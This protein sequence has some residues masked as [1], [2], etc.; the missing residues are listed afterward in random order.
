MYVPASDA[1]AR[2]QSSHPV[3]PRHRPVADDDVGAAAARVRRAL[4]RH[5]PRRDNGD[6][7]VRSRCRARPVRGRRRP[8]RG[9]RA[10]PHPARLATHRRVDQR[11]I[12]ALGCWQSCG[13]MPV[14]RAVPT[15]ARA[16]RLRP[17]VIA[18][19][20][21]FGGSRGSYDDLA[22]P[23]RH[24]RRRRERLLD[25]AAVRARATASRYFTGNEG[26]SPSSS[27]TLSR[28]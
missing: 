7:G 18:S 23:D 8:R 26:G 16:P 3:D 9:R 2:R 19:R 10:G 13:P 27:S 11:R 22:H 15:R 1:R 12:R 17:R 21:R 5:S 20:H 14:Q 24:G 4:R 6:R 28:R 25:F